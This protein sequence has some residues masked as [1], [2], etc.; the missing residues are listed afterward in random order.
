[1]NR[2][3]RQFIGSAAMLLVVTAVLLLALVSGGMSA[4]PGAYERP[5]PLEWGVYQ[6][7]WSAR[8][9]DILER[10]L[11]SFRTKPKYVMFY[12]DLLRGFPK[13]AMDGVTRVGA[14]PV[15]SLELWSWH[16]GRSS[17]FLPAIN[18]GK[19]DKPFRQWAASA[20][21]DGRRILLRFGFEFNGDWFSWS[22]DPKAYVT[23][24]RRAHGIFA[25]V[26]ASNVEWVWSPNVVSCPDK[27]END[28]HLYYPGDEYVDW[29]GVDGYN[30]GDHHDQWH[31]WQSFSEVF[32]DVLDGFE[33]RYPQKPIIIAEFGCAPG[34]PAAREAWIR[35][36]FRFLE[37]RKQVRAAVWFNYDKRSEGE[38]N[39][40]IDAT[41][42][43]LEAFN[44]T[45]AGQ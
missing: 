45:F 19:F 5:M 42:G 17:A 18:A 31:K 12:R 9:G 20:K 28:M 44:E 27:P 15:V 36:A 33:E 34:D 21:K 10:E 41:A 40:R 25:A 4:A 3:A 43:S 7:F 13:T 32:T 14:T 8:Y 23:A 30:F 16:G 2:Q 38:P 1:M 37:T 11:A 39:W 22:G 24:W 29:V 35:R 6:I 26:G